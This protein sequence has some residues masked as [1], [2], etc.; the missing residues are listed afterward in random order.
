MLAFVQP[1]VLFLVPDIVFF[2][3]LLAVFLISNGKLTLVGK[4]LKSFC[5]FFS[6]LKMVN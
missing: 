2:F 6:S 4:F 5:S 1:V 3:W